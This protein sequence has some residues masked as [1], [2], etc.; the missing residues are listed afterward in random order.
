MY[1]EQWLG[2]TTMEFSLSA[3]H[4]ALQDSQHIAAKFKTSTWKISTDK[5]S[6]GTSAGCVH[7]PRDVQRVV[8]H[9]AWALS[10]CCVQIKTPEE[11]YCDACIESY[12]QTDTSNCSWLL[13]V[14]IAAFTLGLLSSLVLLVS[15][16]VRGSPCQVS[17]FLS[18]EVQATNLSTQE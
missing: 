9:L 18:L 6:S 8:G 14:E 13:G 15:T 7:W 17:S 12:L 11:T 10:S 5:I 2:G 16:S 1:T 3:L 4:R